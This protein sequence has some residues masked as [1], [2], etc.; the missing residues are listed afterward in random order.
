M[1][2]RPE[3]RL[4]RLLGQGNAR[5][6]GL[7]SND[8]RLVHALVESKQTYLFRSWPPAGCRDDAKRALWHSIKRRMAGVAAGVEEARIGGHMK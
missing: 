6:L 3:A 7:H 2:H 8:A 5:V 1:H 4:H